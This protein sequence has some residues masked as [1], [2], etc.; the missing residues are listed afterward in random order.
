ML[1]ENTRTG[2]FIRLVLLLISV[3]LMIPVVLMFGFLQESNASRQKEITLLKDEIVK[4]QNERKSLEK[5]ISSIEKEAEDLKKKVTEYEE[6]LEAKDSK[7]RELEEKNSTYEEILKD[8]EEK[9]KLYG[10]AGVTDNKNQKVAYLTFDDGPSINTDKVLDILK[11]YGIKATF[12]VVGKENMKDR[13]K[14]ILDEGHVIG[15]HTYSHEYGKIYSSVEAF[16]EDVDKLN[17]L[18]EEFTGQTTE[19]LRFP[20]GFHNTVSK[21][22]GGSDIMQKI[23][24]EALKR[25]YKYFDWN[26]TS[27]DA[28]VAGGVLP[29]DTI[30]KN[31]LSTTRNRK[32][33]IVLMHDTASKNTTVQAL[34]DIIEG[35]AAQGYKFGVLSKYVQAK[36]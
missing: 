17:S 12:F 4:L 27:G 5:K 8:M 32:N 25:G 22:A 26:V 6:E 36:N 14:R 7:I 34:P 9:L 3:F 21:A 24:D 18:L 15:N 19:I 10:A 30:V 13:Y 20:G 16:F 33:I 11:K 29:K 35:L 23:A 2:P 28:T 1:Q 31:V